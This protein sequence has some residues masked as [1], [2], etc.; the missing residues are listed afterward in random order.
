MSL[1]FNTPKSALNT[2]SKVIQN[3]K[4]GPK[5]ISINENITED[6]EYTIEPPDGYDAIS[7]I[8]V[9]VDAPNSCLN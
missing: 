3:L 9:T 2:T 8:N 1:V 4:G 7:S 6:G 5:L